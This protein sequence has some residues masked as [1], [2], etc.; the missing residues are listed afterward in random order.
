MNR[1][2]IQDYARTRKKSRTAVYKAIREGRIRES[3]HRNDAGKTVLDADLAD[4]ELA[5]NTEPAMIRDPDAIRAGI[6]A[7]RDPTPGPLFRETPA[8]AATAPGRPPSPDERTSKSLSSSRAAL[9]AYEARLRRL[10]YEERIGKLIEVDV[11]K[12]ELFR[13]NRMVRDALLA[14]P[15]RVAPLL[16]GEQDEDRIRALLGRELA[17]V[18]KALSDEFGRKE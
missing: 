13:S 17:T 11:V 16:A 2:S 14:V 7:T 8:A 4:L 15:N 3:V 1:L 12:V 9:A 5:R 18:L 10:D 6:D